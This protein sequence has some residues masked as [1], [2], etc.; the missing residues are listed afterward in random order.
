MIP[1]GGPLDGQTIKVINNQSLGTAFKEISADLVSSD[2]DNLSGVEVRLVFHGNNQGSG[3]N[4]LEEVF[5]NA[6]SGSGTVAT[7]VPQAV[8]DFSSNSTSSDADAGS[9]ASEFAP[10]S[11][12]ASTGYSGGTRSVYGAGSGGSASANNANGEFFQFVITPNPGSKL[13]MDT[14]SLQAKRG[15]S[16]P[17]R[18]TVYAIPSGGS[19]GGQLVTL[20]NNASISTGFST[21]SVDLATGAFDDLSALEIRV[22]FHG[23][24]QGIGSN[25][26][27]N[28]EIVGLSD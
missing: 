9:S 7:S 2:F 20:V 19:Q 24:N 18:V 5:L 10:G 28:V 23:N 17:D 22:V 6:I 25:F 8:Y 14:L 1:A 27:D 3:S 16:S 13:S 12:Y 21:F 11:G 26:V 15:G 4:F